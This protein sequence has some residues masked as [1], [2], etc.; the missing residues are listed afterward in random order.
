MNAMQWRKSSYSGGSTQSSCVEVAQ[1]LGHVR[2]SKNPHGP[3]LAV[4]VRS[5]VADL[6]G[7]RLTD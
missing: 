2:D 7:G 3:V 1:T 6:R 5:L 4:D